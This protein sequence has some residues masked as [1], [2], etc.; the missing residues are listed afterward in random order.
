MPFILQLYALFKQGTQDPKFED[1]P[2]AGAF[3][4]K[5]RF[6]TSAIR[7]GSNLKAAATDAD[8]SAFYRARQS[9]TSG[10]SSRT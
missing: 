10:P 1:A 2:K 8:L 3:D 5:V 4:F 9:T 6:R 7:A